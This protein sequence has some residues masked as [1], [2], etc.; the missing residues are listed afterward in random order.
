MSYPIVSIFFECKEY[1]PSIKTALDSLLMQSFKH[2]EVFVLYEK[3]NT[4]LHS[5]V[6]QYQTLDARIFPVQHSNLLTP[7][8]LIK[9]ARGEWITFLEAQSCLTQDALALFFEKTFTYTD[10][11]AFVSSA[12]VE[13]NRSVPAIFQHTIPLVQSIEFYHSD[14]ITSF[15]HIVS[16]LQFFYHNTFP[17]TGIF[18]HRSVL[19]TTRWTP[20]LQKHMYN[21]DF[22]LHL[23]TQFPLLHVEE[24]LFYNN[25]H[26]LPTSVDHQ[27]MFAE[28]LLCIKM[29]HSNTFE[30]ILT[31]QPMECVEQ[32]KHTL[33][34][35]L[36]IA[37][38]HNSLLYNCGYNTLC[39]E[40]IAE[41]ICSA[42]CAP[43][44]QTLLQHTKER[45]QQLLLETPQFL[46]NAIAFLL[47][48]DEYS[49]YTVKTEALSVLL[50]RS[51]G[52][53]LHYNPS[54]AILF[55][56]F[57]K[58]LFPSIYSEML[59]Y[60]NEA[61]PLPLS[62]RTTVTHIPANT[63]DTHATVISKTIL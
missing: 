5:L 43:Y 4:V 10:A 29:L 23:S 45:V 46:Q 44:K 21:Y 35:M 34:Y 61:Y 37:L 7:E 63:D 59:I 15:T 8:K 18:L 27:Q 51:G 62:N 53:L 25:T 9:L 47:S 2:W 16:P 6:L 13:K 32:Y 38:N 40:R 56:N 14:E 55:L 57:Y 30:N 3:K 58:E 49:H 22:L 1:M 36:T 60:F 26:T 17:L 52:Q 12:I 33:D 31:S 39:I 20:A 54:I 50:A 28:A 42:S 11:R 19:T 48:F 41:W 24:S